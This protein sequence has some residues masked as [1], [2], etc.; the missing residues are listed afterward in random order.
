MPTLETRTLL[1]GDLVSLEMQSSEYCVFPVESNPMQVNVVA[2]VNPEVEIGAEVIS[3]AQIRF[4]ALPRHEGTNPHFQWLRNGNP[5]AGEQGVT[6]LATGLRDQDEISVMMVSSLDCAVPENVFSNV[7]A[8]GKVLD[9]N[10]IDQDILSTSWNLYPNPNTG[11][12]RVEGEVPGSGAPLRL[13]VAN[14]LGQWVFET[15]VH[16]VNGRFL[17]D[18]HLPHLPAGTYQLYLEAEGKREVR[19]FTKED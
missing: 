17:V 12:F 8:I 15:E 7:L 2:Q 6:Y 1:D 5:I 19:R 16:P 11:R 9:V 4:V 3:A 13:R 14:A 10:S 18:I